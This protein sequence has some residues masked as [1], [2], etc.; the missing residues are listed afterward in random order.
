MDSVFLAT[1][2][3][4]AAGRPRAREMYH[5]GAKL[6]QSSD[7]KGVTLPEYLEEP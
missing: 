5:K 1:P 3:P 4:C 6:G 7:M 2:A